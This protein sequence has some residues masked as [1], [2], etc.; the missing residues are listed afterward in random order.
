MMIQQMMMLMH[1]EM[2]LRQQALV[3]YQEAEDVDQRIQRLDDVMALNE[4]LNEVGSILGM[5]LNAPVERSEATRHGPSAAAAAAAAGNN[6]PPTVHHSPSPVARGRFV[7]RAGGLFLPRIHFPTP[8]PDTEDNDIDASSDEVAE[9]VIVPSDVDDD[10]EYVGAGGVP[11]HAGNEENLSVVGRNIGSRPNY[12]SGNGTDRWQVTSRM[13]APSM[14]TA[15]N[16]SSTVVLSRQRDQPSSPLLSR[17]RDRPSTPRPVRVEQPSVSVSVNVLHLP[18]SARSPA[19]MPSHTTT[20][21]AVEST[22]G[23]PTPAVRTQRTQNGDHQVRPAVAAEQRAGP[24]SSSNS[25]STSSRQPELPSMYRLPATLNGNT[26]AVTISQQQ[27]LV[28]GPAVQQASSANTDATSVGVSQQTNSAVNS[29]QPLAHT[30]SVLMEPWPLLPATESHASSSVSTDRSVIAQPA[31]RQHVE[32]QQS[33]ARGRLARN[34]RPPA[35]VTVTSQGPQRAAQ[36]V[37]RA[38]LPLRRSS[39]RNTLGRPAGPASVSTLRPRMVPLPHP[40]LTS[41]QQSFASRATAGARTENSSD[42]LRPRRRSE[43]AHEIMFPPQ[44]NTEQ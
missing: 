12:V 3:S 7:P 44:N 33:Q 18:A 16:G 13:A 21:P 15:F 31:S 26:A 43:I 1:L 19:T 34:G 42:V 17:R 22:A 8:Y 30:S 6:F 23:A 25:T 32:Y 37:N 10:E 11:S 29:S 5:L 38:T 40:P 28:A 39:V 2:Q 14:S 24:Q 41:R 27:S 35:D 36:Q 4:H 9:E 20:L